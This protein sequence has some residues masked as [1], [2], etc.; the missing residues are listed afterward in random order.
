MHIKAWFTHYSRYIVYN[1]TITQ[2]QGKYSSIINQKVRPGTTET[3][4]YW[5][6]NLARSGWVTQNRSDDRLWWEVIVTHF[7][8]QHHKLRS[9]LFVLFTNCQ[10][11]IVLLCVPTVLHNFPE[12]A[13]RILNRP[14][15]SSC[16][17]ITRC[18]EELKMIH[19]RSTLWHEVRV[20]GLPLEFHLKYDASSTLFSTKYVQPYFYLLDKG[21][22]RHFHTVNEIKTIDPLNITHN[23]R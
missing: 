5:T 12:N 10:V 2:T 9:E 3:E 17:Q 7:H 6:S 13:T 18:F 21:F 23:G 16:T 15:T 22:S 19:Q 1:E 20:H 14:G 4:I 8:R 11:F